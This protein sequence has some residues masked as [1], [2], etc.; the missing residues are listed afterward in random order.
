M[1]TIYILYISTCQFIN[2]KSNINLL[3]YSLFIYLLIH[4]NLLITII[5]LSLRFIWF[6]PGG[7]YPIFFVLNIINSFKLLVVTTAQQLYS[8]GVKMKLK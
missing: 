5:N 7:L 6:M 8:R 3:I 4:C 1:Y 2:S